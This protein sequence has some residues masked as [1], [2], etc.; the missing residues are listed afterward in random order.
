MYFE[1]QKS[2]HSIFFFLIERSVFTLFANAS[3][4]P[5]NCLLLSNNIHSCDSNSDSY[6]KGLS[7]ALL[8]IT[9]RALFT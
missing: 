9:S 3:P 7:K 2:N 6:N 1:N 5:K 8:G 4:E